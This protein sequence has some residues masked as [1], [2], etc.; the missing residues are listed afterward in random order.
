MRQHCASALVHQQFEVQVEHTPNAIALIDQ[1][2]QYT[3]RQL[4]ARANQLAR[5]LRQRGV[6][7]EVL[8]G[9][10]LPRSPELIIA[11]LAILKAGGAYIPMDPEYPAER[12]ALMRADSQTPLL[13]TH[14]SHQADWM[15][16][17]G[18]QI[19]CLDAQWEA[20]A[21]EADENL[22]TLAQPHT[23]AYVIYTSGST[24]KPKGVMIERRSL[25]AYV[26]TA[27]EA[28]ALQPGDR[29]LQFASISFDTSAEEIYPCLVRGATLVLRTEEMIGSVQT[30]LAR[31]RDWG[32]TV[33][34]LPTAFWHFI[35]AE[36][37][38]TG[39]KPP[40]HL[41][42]VIIGG[43][44]AIAARLDQWRQHVGDAVRLVNTYGPTETTIVATMCDLA[45]PQA[46]ANADA[47]PIGRAIPQARLHILDDAMQP[48]PSGTV[49]ELYIGGVGV[50][51]GYLNRPDLTAERFL[52]DPFSAE[53]GA[54]LYKSG[55]RV[56]D[57]GDGVLE[58]LGRADHQVKIRG[59]RVELFEIEAVLNQHPTVQDAIVLAPEDSLGNKRLVAYLLPRDRATADQ[60]WMATLK[61]YLHTKLP[62]Y[63]VPS[64]FLVLE[65]LPLSPSGKVDRHALPA[66]DAWGSASPMPTAVPQTDLE[67][68]I[69]A[70]W[71]QIL[72]LPAIGLDDNFFDLGGNSLLAAQLVSLLAATLSLDL[73][74]R[75]VYESPTIATLA[76]ALQTLQQSGGSVPMALTDLSAQPIPNPPAIARRQRPLGDLQAPQTVFLTGATG[77]LGA[78]LL[79]ELLHQTQARVFCL[80]RAKNTRDGFA[81]LRATFAKYGLPVASLEG[82]VI[83]LPGN[84]GQPR[85]GLSRVQFARLADQVEVIY[86]S[87]AMVNFVKPYSALEAENVLGTR[88]ILELAA[89]GRQK[90]VNY[91]S[92]VGVFGA[93]AYFTGQSVVYED[94]DLDRS[95]DFLCWDDGYA[96]SKW[97]AEKMLL[98]AK[99][100]GMPIT[101]FRPGF[102]T[103]NSHTGATN[104]QDFLSRSLVGCIQLGAYPD[105][106]N[107]KNQVVTVDYASRTILYLSQQPDAI[108][109]TFHITPWSPARDFAWNDLFA[110]VQ[111]YGYPLQR[112]DYS[113][114]KA[115]LSLQC[116]HDP[117]NAL[118][119]LLPFLN[120]KIYAQTLTIL[121]LYQNTA[122][123]DCS[124]A[125]AALQGS[126]I[127]CP[128]IDRQMI[129][130]YLD[131]FGPQVGLPQPLPVSLLA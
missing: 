25:A 101:V 114:W 13:L 47:S 90:P 84:L 21:Q 123:F 100:Q 45:G 121:E 7:P 39:L 36:F 5:F 34:N 92:T 31:S 64:Q 38:R 113:T 3:Y 1:G 62:G 42:L 70:I 112:L 10:C 46:I 105:L 76:Q 12:L 131:A 51:R 110:W 106:V 67:A 17:D 28:Y 16:A 116:R 27:A 99:A 77:F 98:A 33:W 59:F 87:G 126:D 41:R 18:T 37:A 66:P 120:E 86:H 128:V 83:P 48:V 129:Y 22:P 89:Q 94:E 109:G 30:F 88:A 61:T 82:R 14:R 72:Q 29:A 63:M 49:G 71:S 78:F 43:E 32:I 58:F 26:H 125:I 75:C 122:D 69:A 19:L 68:Q 102:I 73:P 57:R 103:G 74:V 81:R 96:Q 44:K 2:R 115:K 56:C 50:A 97:V 95:R 20:I 79:H 118:Y 124:A 111:D 107:F 53:P 8:V 80:V 54:R 117:N 23:L 55:D 24:G 9:L 60:P 52:P 104:L 130:T 93:I 15:Q 85:L 40:E 35:T 127:H 108:G 119:P 65:S 11:L 6:G 91:V 4:N